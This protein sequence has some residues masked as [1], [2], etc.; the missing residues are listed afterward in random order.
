LTIF[1]LGQQDPQTAGGRTVTIRGPHGFEHAAQAGG[2]SRGGLGFFKRAAEAGGEMERAAWPGSLSLNPAAHHFD[3]ARA[4]R[5]TQ[6]G[7]AELARGGCVGLA[8]GLE[9][10]LALVSGNSNA[11]IAHGEVQRASEAGSDAASPGAS[12][13]ITSMPRWR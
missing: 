2:G 7:A 1:V 4:D 6:A 5:Q 12:S 9:D 10:Q 8:E 3:Q 13:T 11:G